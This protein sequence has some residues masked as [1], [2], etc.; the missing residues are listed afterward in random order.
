MIC[1]D[2]DE[3][4]EGMYYNNMAFVIKLKK[5]KWNIRKKKQLN[6]VLICG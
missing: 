1:V 4:I 6:N 2:E 3:S 5:K